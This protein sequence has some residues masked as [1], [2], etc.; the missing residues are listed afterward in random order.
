MRKWRRMMTY[1]IVAVVLL[2]AVGA[3]LFVR[4]NRQV[5][6]KIEILNADATGGTALVVY[7][8]GV[9]SFQEKVNRAFAD[10]LASAGW[11][12]EMTT[13]SSQ[14]PTDLEGYDLLVLGSPTYASAPAKPFQSYL[15]ALG[16]LG[17]QRTVIILS[18][19]GQTDEVVATTEDLVCEANGELVKSLPIWTRAPNEEMYGISDP[20]E[21]MRQA[22]MEISLPGQ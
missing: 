21:I 19:A 6:S 2:A 10:G 18:G 4:M 7:H 12:V 15:E 3:W 22:A 20:V 14:A 11:R 5:V 13:A 16:D 8:P 1:L 9:S 17:G